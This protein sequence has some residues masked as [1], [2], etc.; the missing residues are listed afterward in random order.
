MKS[1]SVRLS[2]LALALT[3]FAASTVTSKAASHNSMSPVVAMGTSPAA[4][5]PPSRPGP[6]ALD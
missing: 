4:L 3:G 2:V 6:C 5:C 1:F